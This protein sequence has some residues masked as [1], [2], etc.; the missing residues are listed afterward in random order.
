LKSEYKHINAETKLELKS[1]QIPEP[2]G[3][4]CADVIR[5]VVLPNECPLFA[6]ACK[7]EN[8]IGPCMVSSEGA[9]AAFYNYG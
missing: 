3:C 9:C 6:K 7:P 1:V 5:G 8:P 4:R 2:I